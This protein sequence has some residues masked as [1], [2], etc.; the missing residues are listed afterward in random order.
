MAEPLQIG[1][2]T[3]TKKADRN[4]WSA[5]PQA[6]QA[7]VTIQDRIVELNMLYGEVA[8]LNSWNARALAAL[9]IAAADY[10]ERLPRLEDTSPVTSPVTPPT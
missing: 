10:V 7:H 8:Q 2:T 4:S 5:T 6:Y 3:C 9:L 1:S